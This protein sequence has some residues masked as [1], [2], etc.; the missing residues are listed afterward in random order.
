LL[1]PSK[2]AKDVSDDEVLGAADNLKALFKKK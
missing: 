1:F 2:G